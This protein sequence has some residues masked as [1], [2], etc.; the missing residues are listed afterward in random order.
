[1]ALSE[2]AEVV[3]WGPLDFLLV[4]LPPGTGDA[5]LTVC[6]TYQPK[7]AIVVTTPQELSVADVRRCIKMF[8][9]LKLPVLGLVENMAYLRLEGREISVFGEGGGERLS[10]ELRVPL[11]IRIPLAPEINRLKEPVV[12]HPE[13]EAAKAF[14]ELADKVIESVFKK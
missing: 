5:P 14:L 9:V 7:G 1:K 12:L 11:L 3:E 4:D 8:E 2:L 6:Q 10:K 13:T